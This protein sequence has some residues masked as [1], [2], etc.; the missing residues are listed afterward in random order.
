MVEGGVTIVK[1]LLFL[2]N[3]VLWV[4]GL[5]LI[6]VGSI[7][8]LKFDNV[9]DILGDERLATPIILL[10]IG[11]LCTLLGFLGC[12][13]AIR[14]N[15]C[16]TVSFA[17]LLALLITCEIAAVIIGYALHDS[18]R[19][20]ISNQLQ[21]GMVRYHESRGVESAWDK[22]HQLFECCGVTNSSDWLT[23]TTIPDS[24]CIEEMEGCARENAPLFERGCIHSVE[25]WVLKN[26][27]MVGGI[28]AVL[29]AIQLVGVCFACCLSKSILKDFHDFYY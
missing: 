24:C 11:S 19:L 29:A 27:A 20:G 15:Y 6:I 28:C 25:Q 17:V 21:T 8:Q 16:L 14:E 10:V 23:F 5:S 13:G 3:L 7:L 4:G 12:C 9:L 26:G 1:Y 18:F 22:T 2:A